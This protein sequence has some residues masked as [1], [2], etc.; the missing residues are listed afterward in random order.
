M[1][2]WLVLQRDDGCRYEERVT[3]E[4]WFRQMVMLGC[5]TDVKFWLEGRLDR[6]G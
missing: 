4:T 6:K 1:N 3:S 2:T 5:T